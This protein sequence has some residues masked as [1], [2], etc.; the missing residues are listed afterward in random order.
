LL[1]TSFIFTSKRGRLA[2][3]NNTTGEK[4]TTEWD[5]EGSSKR[6]KYP[7]ISQEK[8]KTHPRIISFH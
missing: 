2:E 4:E 3:P 5:V 6:E 8:A 1:S 7:K